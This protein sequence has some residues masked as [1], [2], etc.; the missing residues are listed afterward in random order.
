[1]TDSDF[2]EC[3]HCGTHL[4]ARYWSFDRNIEQVSYAKSG[5]KVQASINV[6]HSEGLQCYCSEDCALAVI[7]E[8]MAAHG[9]SHLYPGGGPIELCARCSKP[10]DLTATHVAYNL[11]VGTESREPWLTQY[12]PETGETIAVV[13]LACEP[14]PAEQ[15]TEET[16]APT[17]ESGQPPVTEPSFAAVLA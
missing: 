17:A 5:G 14:A 13:C 2:G 10:M 1:M 8:K 7:L 12:T 6:I 16:E 3:G 11:L 4:T 9:F 15:A